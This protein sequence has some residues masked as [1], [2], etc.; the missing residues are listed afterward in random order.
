MNI[1]GTA[2]PKDKKRVSEIVKLVVQEANALG[3]TGVKMNDMRLHLTDADQGVID[4][5]AGVGDATLLSADPPRYWNFLVVFG[6]EK[7]CIKAA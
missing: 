1:Q 3:K 7:T 2:D 6:A 4:R 5:V